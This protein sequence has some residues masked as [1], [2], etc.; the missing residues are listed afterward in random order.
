M[1]NDSQ[2]ET[3]TEPAKSIRLKIFG[4][5]NAGV[6]ILEHIARNGARGAE[7]IAVNTESDSLNASSAAEKI[8]LETKLMRGLGTGGDPERGRIAAEEHSAT[9]KTACEGVDVIFVVAGLGGG[10]GTGISPFLSQVA[11]DA[12]AL[13]LAFGVTPF[14]CEGNARQRQA[15][16][17]LKEL[18]AAADGVICLPNQKLFK[19]IDEN[20]SVVEM[21]ERANELL[22]ETIANVSRLIACKGLIELR[23][24]D[25]CGFL[26]DR[27][28]EN[29]FA[30]ADASGATRSRDVMEKLLAHPL[31]DNGKT[32]TE[33]DA[34]LVSLIGGPDLT[35]ADINRVME[36]I[37]SKCGRAQVIMGAAIDEKFQERLAVTI[38]AARHVDAHSAKATEEAGRSE[39]LSAP[40]ELNTQIHRV[41][42]SRPHSR[43]VAPPPA[44]T[45]EQMET[46]MSR[47]SPGATRARK[48]SNKMRQGTL[49][50]EIVSKGRFDKSEPTIHKGEDLD[51]PT[52]IRRGVALN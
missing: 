15:R 3:T 11:R 18:K 2:I 25:L 8:C 36:P 40:A 47:Q 26:R 9:L 49:P 34:V 30:T 33:S 31:L 52:Y 35:M 50:L 1:Q 12:G 39:G 21:F 37:N 32:L 19:L 10:A 14:D 38:I 28:S 29:Q 48:S 51:I 42:T 22:A 7:L 6:K 46:L 5:G 17:G 24:A 27:H 23:F 43:F 16:Q 45:P 13:V 44:M 4:V 20:T 41:A